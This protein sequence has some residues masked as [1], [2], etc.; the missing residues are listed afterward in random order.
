[1]FIEYGVVIPA[2]VAA[3]NGIESRTVVEAVQ[4]V[5]NSVGDDCES[6]SCTQDPFLEL[7]MLFMVARQTGFV[8]E[9]GSNTTGVPIGAAIH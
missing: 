7:Y 4:N 8:Y 9:L 3:A 1:V 2:A 5:V 6:S